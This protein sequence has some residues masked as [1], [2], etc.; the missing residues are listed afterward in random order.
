MKSRKYQKDLAS[1]SDSEDELT[2]MKNR[3]MEDIKQE[4]ESNLVE[5]SVD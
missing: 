1:D 4:Y 2:A 3:I 5:K